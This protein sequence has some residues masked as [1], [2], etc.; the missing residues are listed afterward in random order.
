MQEKHG[1]NGLKSENNIT[2]TN[3]KAPPPLI[4]LD[5]SF[6]GKGSVLTL[7]ALVSLEMIYILKRSL[8]NLLSIPLRTSAFFQGIFTSHSFEVFHR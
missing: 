4:I 5:H 6:D 8:L 7:Q 1:H 3:P 2:S